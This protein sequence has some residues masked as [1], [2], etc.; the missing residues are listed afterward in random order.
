MTIEA[1]QR[2]LP[3]SGDDADRSRAQATAAR[4]R[5]QRAGATVLIR[6]GSLITVLAAWQWFGADINPALFTTPTAVARAAVGMIASGEL[7]AYLW[8]SLIVLAIGLV[9]ASLVGIAVGLLLA[10]Y[11]VIDVAVGVYITFLYSIPTV[12]LVPLIVLWAG[13]E[14]TA[15]VIILFLFAFFPMAI[16]TYQGVKN[17]DPRLIEV[18]RSFRCSERQLWTNIVLPGALPFVLTGLRLAVGRGLIGMVLADLY[19]AVSGIGYLI[20]RAAGTYQVDKMFVPIVTLGI[21][22]VVLTALLRV[23][24]IKLAPWT[25]AGRPE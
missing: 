9:L 19:T 12:A 2:V 18:G 8:P 17:V 1:H 23:M 13:Y 24:E 6:L 16:N 20:V 5:R 25:E 15:K 3:A 10:R 22:G 7:W 14:T 21:L 11:W 4:R